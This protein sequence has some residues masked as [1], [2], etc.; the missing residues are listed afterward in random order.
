M[1]NYKSEEDTG[2]Q[3]CKYRYNAGSPQ[4]GIELHKTSERVYPLAMQKTTT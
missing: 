3:W 4:V 2:F 1:E